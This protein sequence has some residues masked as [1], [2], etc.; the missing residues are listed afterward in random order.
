MGFFNKWVFFFLNEKYS[1]G[2]S[3]NPSRVHIAKFIEYLGFTFPINFYSHPKF[4]TMGK[5]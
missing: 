5:N 4:K 3:P 2:F 1:D